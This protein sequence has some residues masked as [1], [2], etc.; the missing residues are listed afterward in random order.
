MAT[1]EVLAGK[2]EMARRIFRNYVSW[3]HPG[4]EFSFCHEIKCSAIQRILDGTLKRLIVNEPPR[5]GKSELF[6]IKLPSMF[7]GR[8]PTKK[9]MLGSYSGT[10]ADKMNRKVQQLMSGDRFHELFPHVH[11]PE[12]GV[13][14]RKG[15]EI[16]KE[17]E[18]E[19]VQ[20]G[21]GMKTAGMQGAATGMGFHLGIID[22]P[23]KNFEEGASMTIRDKVWDTFTS[24]FWTRQEN[25]D[26]TIVL[27]M[28]R[29]HEDDLTGRLLDMM[30]YDDSCEQWEVINLPAV[31]EGSL[32]PEDRRNEGEALWPERYPIEFLDKARKTLGSWQFGGIYQQ[33]PQPEGGALHQRQE[34]RLLP[35]RPRGI[36]LV[37][38]LGH[39]PEVGLP[40]VR[41][42]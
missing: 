36:G 27:V 24:T 25:T 19:I 31:A 41:L 29:W 3:V 18:F 4:Y 14:A 8:N 37:R 6:S 40:R 22:D 16:R 26:A 2:R 38:A 21:G 15:K 10:L 13:R 42:R 9:V 30:K 28:T 23:F 33:H 7:L 32:M 20:Y 11:L 12:T 35:D 17:E 1:E 39:H 5:H 34:T